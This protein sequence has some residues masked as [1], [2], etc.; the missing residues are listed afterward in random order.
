MNHSALKY[1]A[2]LA[3][4]TIITEA[5]GAL[6][7]GQG[8]SRMVSGALQTLIYFGLC[9]WFFLVGLKKYQGTPPQLKGL[10]MGGVFCWAVSYQAFRLLYSSLGPGVVS[11]II[12]VL[13]VAAISFFLGIKGSF[14]QKVDAG[15]IANK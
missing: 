5:Y 6:Y 1:S 8:A 9:Y 4:V 2:T 12:P 11:M 7:H 3:V 15:D 13:L 10:I 14:T